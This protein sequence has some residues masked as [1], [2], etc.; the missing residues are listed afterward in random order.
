MSG[1]RLVAACSL[2]GILLG[3]GAV[4]AQAQ[5]SLADVARQEAERRKTVAKSGKVYTNNDTKTGRPL[6]TGSSALAK[7]A[8]AAQ[9]RAAAGEQA[10]DEGGGKG[11]AGKADGA[12][13][14]A[15]RPAEAR[16]RHAGAHLEE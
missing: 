13:G 12:T 16:P 14:R 3:T 11:A 6:T 5:P 8:E 1:W 7:A 15:R 10:S 4:L 9:G 2:S